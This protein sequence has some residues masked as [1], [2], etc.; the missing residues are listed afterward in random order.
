MLR[1]AAVDRT[2]LPAVVD[3]SPIKQGR[4]M[5][6]TDI[7]VVGPGQLTAVRP[8]KVLLF[9][10]DLMTE[11][12]DA[13]PEVEASGGQWVNIDW[14]S[15]GCHNGTRRHQASRGDRTDAAYWSPAGKAQGS[16]AAQGCQPA[17]PVLR[18]GAGGFRLNWRRVPDSRVATS[19]RRPPAR[20]R[21]RYARESRGGG[22]PGG[23]IGR[24]SSKLGWRLRRSGTP[25]FLLYRGCRRSALCRPG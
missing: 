5:P 11:A 7:P 24:R 13:F 23:S 2:L 9:L 15:L 12:R 14:L 1:C 16:Q 20:R 21:L 3:I 8:A 18:A 10:A 19:R 22:R 17:R 25:S 4:R 6:G